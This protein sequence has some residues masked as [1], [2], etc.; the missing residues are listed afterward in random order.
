MSQLITYI[1]SYT[2]PT[3]DRTIV[4]HI[5][6]GVSLGGHAAW[7]CIIH[8]ARVSTAIAIIGCP[9]Y[10]ALMS[11]RARLSKLPSWTESEIPGAK[12]LGSK[13][14][15]R[16]LVTAVEKFDPAGLFLRPLRTYTSQKYDGGPSQ[17]E[18]KR[19]VPLMSNTL[20]GK[21]MLN[22]AGGAD[23][24]VPYKCAEPFCRWLKKATASNGWFGNR[25]VHFEDIIYD[26]V[27]HDM[28]P[29]MA[30]KANEFIIET[31]MHADKSHGFSK[32]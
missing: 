29:E 4:D 20:Q 27:G 32:M 2:F 11:D 19:L 23:K 10:V 21:R 24:L 8:E 22:M 5:V 6:L 15:P 13:D 26:G 17:D 28:S 25:S 1:S 16:S 3:S 7:Q 9:D 30:K 14:F 31:L 12:F 18:E